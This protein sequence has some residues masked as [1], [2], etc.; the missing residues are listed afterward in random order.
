VAVDRGDAVGLIAPGATE[1]TAGVHAESRKARAG[2]AEDA[3]QPAAV[4]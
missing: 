3:E 1:A 4:G 2:L